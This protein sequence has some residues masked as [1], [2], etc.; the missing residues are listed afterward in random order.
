MLSST[1][2]DY[3]QFPD[4]ELADDHGFLAHGGD[5][6]VNTLLS[7]YQQG[8]FPWFNEGEPILWWSPNP[9]MILPTK[10][11]HISR[12]LTKTIRSNRYQI[13]CNTAFA[14]V[15]SA[16]S[17]PRT[18]KNKTIEP[19][20]WITPAMKDAYLALFSAGYA[21]SIEAWEKQQLVGGLY[22]VSIAGMF[23]PIDKLVG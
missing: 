22:G 13:T 18:P 5:L 21:V 16:C 9:R 10:D 4:P 2:P 19:G 15:I 17:E 1:H 12:S 23:F 11:M 7:A 8:I 6:R 20:T 3:I 14:D